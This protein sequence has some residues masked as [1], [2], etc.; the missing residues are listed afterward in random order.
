MSRGVKTMRIGIIGTGWFSKVHAGILSGMEG[1]Q[2][3]AICGTSAEKAQQMASRYGASGYGQLSD[4]LDGERLDAVYICVPPLAH[5]EVER[6]LL[7][8]KIPFLV[9]KPLGIGTEVP[10]D[11]LSGIQSSSL[12][13]S[14]GYHFRYM[15]T[16]LRLKEALARQSA[17]M[18]VGQWMGSMPQVA[19][20]RKQAGSGGQFI[21]QTTHLVDLLRY[22]A[23]EVEEVQALYGQ[24]MQRR[25]EL[26]VEVA[27]VGTVSLRL[28]SG[29][30]ANISN[31]FLLPTGVSRVGL[32]FYT[33]EG[34]LDWSPERLRMSETGQTTEWPN[35]SDPYALES[36]AFIHAVRT[37]D[38]SRILS[39]YADAFRTHLVT[40]A[41]LESA[42]AGRPILISE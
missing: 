4:M 30:I 13:T 26:G 27:D 6:Q 32:T 17:G 2:V 3:K 10:L 21:E 34:M 33:E 22:C 15:E 5:G 9:E 23:G 1:V 14:V 40:C 37:G 41:A 31:T 36:A 25:E 42:A 19:W 7:Q 8:R 39:D 28:R 29:F 20:W 38:A 12:I 24:R 11:I 16:S 18:A 35:G